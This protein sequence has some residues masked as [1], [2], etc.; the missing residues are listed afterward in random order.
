MSAWTTPWW[1]S[2]PSSSAS[3]SVLD[4]YQGSYDEI[5]G[6]FALMPPVDGAIKAFRALSRAFDTYILSS[7]FWNSPSAW[8]AQGRV[9][10]DP[11]RGGRGDSGVQAPDPVPPKGTQPRR[12]PHRRPTLHNGADR[13]AGWVI[14]FGKDGD[15]PEGQSDWPPNV[16]AHID[17]W[18][19]VVAYVT[20]PIVA[21]VTED[22]ADDLAEVAY[23]GSAA[24]RFLIRHH[25]G[26]DVAELYSDLDESGRTNIGGGL[27]FEVFHNVLRHVAERAGKSDDFQR[28]WS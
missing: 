14:H 9:G 5:P 4:N 16:V 22:F 27:P 24:V 12:L 18:P 28:D 20:R 25:V 23:P 8:P 3:T 17:A 13:F 21:T 7:S 6:L 19:D 10:A 1:S 11:P 26:R 15:L 2:A